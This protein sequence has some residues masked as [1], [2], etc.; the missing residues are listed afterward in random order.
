M[1]S[2]TSARS[3]LKTSGLFDTGLAGGALDVTSL[4]SSDISDL[5]SSA[6][7][8]SIDDADEPSTSKADFSTHF[9]MDNWDLLDP[10]TD[11]E[12]DPLGDGSLEA[13]VNLDNFLTGDSFFDD[14]LEVHPVIDI[15]SS[16]MKQ[17]VG[18]HV[19]TANVTGDLNE[20]SSTDRHRKRKLAKISQKETVIKTNLFEIPVKVED[21]LVLDTYLDHDYTAKQMK[22]SQNCDQAV[23][24][25][26]KSSDCVNN[27]FSLELP[28]EENGITDKQ[29][30]RRMKNNV[31]SKRSREQRKQKFVEMDQE[32]E[33][34]II[35]NENLRKKI[36]ELELLAQQMKAELVAKMSGK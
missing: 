2:S 19:T 21:I 36:V 1:I 30:V 31:A 13:F 23:V 7:T 16:E 34:L 4:D 18:E 5:F 29:A 12:A 25:S 6:T 9:L 22:L 35:A 15:P 28:V 26:R 24:S 10:L 33:Q 20:S 14:E 17:K 8:Y 11:L 3:P 27:E 32:A